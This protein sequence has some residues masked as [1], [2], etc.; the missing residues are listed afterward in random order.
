[1]QASEF[2]LTAI[3]WIPPLPGLE[4]V[5]TGEM[6]IA[7]TLP[8]PTGRGVVSAT[9]TTWRGSALPDLRVDLTSDGREITLKGAVG[10]TPLLTG[11]MPL[12]TPWPL[13]VDVD[14]AALPV[15]DLMR[16]FL[17]R[18]RAD[19]FATLSGR[20]LVDLE[21]ASPSGV[22]YEALVD[23]A[24][25][26]FKEPWKAGPFSVRG[27]LDA[28]SIDDLEMQFGLGRLRVAGE[29][30]LGHDA[31]GRLVVAG[32][33]PL[34]YLALVTPVE[35]ADG[36]A[37][38]DV[39]LTGRVARP[40]VAGTVRVAGGLIRQGALRV[41]DIELD[42]TLD[43]RR[44][45]L[46]HASARVA[47]G[48]VRATGAVA[49][50]QTTA[51][52]YRLEVHG[53]GIDVARLMAPRDGGPDITAIV[54][55]DM[56]VVADRLSL[57]ALRGDGSLTSVSVSVAGRTLRLDAPVA[58]AVRAGTLTHGPL[59]LAGSG[60]GVT[61]E[62][63]V[64]IVDGQAQLALGIDGEIDLVVANPMLGD[65]VALA[66]V[67]RVQGR[68]ERDA[69]GWHARGDARVDNA[70]AV[71]TDPAIVVSN[72][73]VA[74]RAEGD[75][76]DVV[77]G[78]ARVGDGTLAVTGGLLLSNAGVDVDLVLRADRVPLDYPTGLR[79]RSSGDF[80][81]TGRSGAYRPGG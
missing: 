74:L 78:S 21:L 17:P 14:L 31:S 60:G 30:G 23:G 26:R 28:V 3:P 63:T 42:A 4:S 47:G 15:G 75:R 43:D 66:G 67:A 41:D 39:T 12:T 61:L 50:E 46:R 10:Q 22:R 69:D 38:I 24:E 79:T 53:Q 57:D 32:V 27:T 37:Q 35:E 52:R 5:L 49:L 73:S 48:H 62:S 54:D 59:R 19:A 29:V 13:H 77:E 55:A 2:P 51:D 33:A 40:T 56:R 65:S 76:I 18:A 58:M 34:S 64:A 16:V 25:G 9:R 36:E 80:R 70:R 11:R 68:V 44:I 45:E 71:F 7:G 1:M 8:A 72:V 81:F 20:G 6:E